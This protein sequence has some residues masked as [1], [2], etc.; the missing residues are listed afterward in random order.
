MLSL[1][2]MD[3]LELVVDHRHL[4]QRVDVAQRVVVD[5]LF[6]VVHQLHDLLMI[7]RRGINGLTSALVPERR[8]A[9]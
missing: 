6:Q 5:E 4:D 8:V 1:L 7:L 2:G 9:C 3:A